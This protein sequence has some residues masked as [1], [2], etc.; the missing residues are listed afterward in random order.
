MIDFRITRIIE[1]STKKFNTNFISKK[2]EVLVK[3]KGK[4]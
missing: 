2:V 4:K 3:G 1:L